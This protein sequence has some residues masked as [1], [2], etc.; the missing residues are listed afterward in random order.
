MKAN[1][2]YAEE[3]T[4]ARRYLLTFIVAKIKK[5]FLLLSANQLIIQPR[6]NNNSGTAVNENIDVMF[7]K[8]QNFTA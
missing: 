3:G 6:S 1:S 7:E 2:A 4:W 8:L 5:L